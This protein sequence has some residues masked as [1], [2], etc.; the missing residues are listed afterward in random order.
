MNPK[1]RKGSTWKIV[2]IALAVAAVVPVFTLTLLYT[3]NVSPIYESRASVVM[4]PK[5][6]NPLVIKDDIAIE[7]VLG[8]IR[9]DS[10]LNQVA[11]RI[12]EEDR[13]TLM[14]A[15]KEEIKMSGPMTLEEVLDSHREAYIDPE[16]NVL[17]VAYQHSDR[18]I[19]AKV[20]NYFADETINY[21]VRTALDMRIR[22]IE[23]LRNRAEHRMGKVVEIREEMLRENAMDDP[24]YQADYKVNYDLYVDMAGN[25]NQAMVDIA[26]IT[27]PIMILDKASPSTV[28]VSPNISRNLALG[29]GI[30]LGVLALLA[31]ILF[32]LCRPQKK[33]PPPL[34]GGSM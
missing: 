34:P 25:Y 23:D 33:T 29:A 26:L 18:I 15:Y 20:A 7:D 14:A 12:K 9:S 19:A 13:Q 30:P 24:I 8:V 4:S 32:G 3:F 17:F 2:I 22:Y 10:L 1:S 16:T 21:Y 31:F 11:N 5:Y 28:P 27:S 6:M